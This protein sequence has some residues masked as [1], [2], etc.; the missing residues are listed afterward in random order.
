MCWAATTSCNPSL[1]GTASYACKQHNQQGEANRLVC[2]PYSFPPILPSA[3]SRLC[4]RMSNLFQL[5]QDSPHICT[6]NIP[7]RLPPSRLPPQHPQKGQE[8]QQEQCESNENDNRFSMTFT[9]L[10]T[11]SVYAKK[12]LLMKS[13]RQ[14]GRER[15]KTKQR[16][17]AK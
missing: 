2:L 5:P 9:T 4:R 13:R 12:K 7:K 11:D 8:C 1:T 3:T 15:E 16:Y 17:L 14:R 6:M 10:T